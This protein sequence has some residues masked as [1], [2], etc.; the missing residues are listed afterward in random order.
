MARPASTSSAR[1]LIELRAP[2]VTS[3]PSPLPP[4]RAARHPVSNALPLRRL[5]LTA[6]EAGRAVAVAVTSYF[7]PVCGWPASTPSARVLISSRPRAPVV[8]SPP[9]PSPPRRAA[10]R[11]VPTYLPP[12]RFHLS[13]AVA[14]AAAG[15]CECA[16]RRVPK[17]YCYI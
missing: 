13:L 1:V 7:A 14:A 2:V 5:H 4:R 9:G 12:R 6:E 10:S 16:R 11:P 8:A 3:S 15:V 17:F